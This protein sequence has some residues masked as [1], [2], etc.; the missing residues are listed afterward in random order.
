MV[1]MTALGTGLPGQS[2][3]GLSLM[4]SHVLNL[5]NE[6]GGTSWSFKRAS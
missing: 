1:P 2:S 3:L 4:A 6:F 5:L